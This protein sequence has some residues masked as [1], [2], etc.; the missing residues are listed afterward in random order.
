MEMMSG[1][2]LQM[3]L[4]ERFRLRIHP[5]T[6]QVSVYR[7]TIAK[8]GQKL[9]LFQDGACTPIDLFNATIVRTPGVTYCAISREPRMGCGSMIPVDG[10]Q[11]RGQNGAGVAL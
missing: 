9:K 7:L 2:M 4:E 1:P 8:G 6:S 10:S 5:E 3:L 11:K